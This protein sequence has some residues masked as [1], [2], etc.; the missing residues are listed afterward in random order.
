MTVLSKPIEIGIATDDDDDEEVMI[1]SSP[2]KSKRLEHQSKQPKYKTGT[3]IQKLFPQGWFEGYVESFWIDDEYEDDVRLY[4]IEYE[5]GD[6]ED[7]EEGDM[8]PLVQFAEKDM[9][10]QTLRQLQRK[11]TVKRAAR[12]PTTTTTTTTTTTH[13][14]A[15][16]AR[17]GTAKGL[18][19]LNPDSGLWTGIF[20]QDK[21]ALLQESLVEKIHANPP[22]PKTLPQPLHACIPLMVEFW[23]LLW[24]RQMIFLEG[25]QTNV[26]VMQKHHFC[27]NHREIDR[28]TAYLRSQIMTLKQ[29]LQQQEKPLT[30]AIW[31]EQV[32]GMA[33]IYRLVNKQESFESDRNPTG[34]IPRLGEWTK[35]HEDYCREIQAERRRDNSLPSFMTRA[36]QAISY[37]EYI[38]LGQKCA[39]TIPPIAKQVHAAG[40]NLRKICNVLQKLGGVSSFRGWQLACDLEE[41]RCLGPDVPDD[42]TLLGPGARNGLRDVFGDDVYNSHNLLDLCRHLQSSMTYCLQLVDLEFPHWGGR[43]VTLKVIEHALCEF[44]KFQ[45]SDAGGFDSFRHRHS[46][47]SMDD[48]PC[49]ECQEETTAENRAR[50]DT[51]FLIVCQQCQ[52]DQFHSIRSAEEDRHGRNCCLAC[53]EIDELTFDD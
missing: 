43:P 34:G 50:C 3:A 52:K 51:C 53:H 7:I 37:D 41:A 29:E 8:P 21:G 25:K 1:V 31:L 5:D 9:K 39:K 38:Q 28:G 40:S 22:P 11:T 18:Q 27:N 24:E 19:T 48:K 2:R 32:L 4:R 10:R 47:A 33:Y 13:R 16:K 17:G 42:F 26:R 49:G 6:A 35:E 44:N 20:G 12:K 14:P 15:K 46:R 23:L 36:H 45:R 30:R